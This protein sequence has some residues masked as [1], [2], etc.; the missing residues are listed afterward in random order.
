MALIQSSPLYPTRAERLALSIAAA[1]STM[2]AE[3]MQSRAER[4]DRA[5]VRLRAETAAQFER[6]R[7][8]ERAHLLGLR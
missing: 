6:Q 1:L 3:R 8:R 7:H 5:E 2:V 4:L